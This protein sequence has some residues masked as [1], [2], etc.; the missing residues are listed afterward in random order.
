MPETGTSP[1][2]LV[3]AERWARLRA[4]PDL[5]LLRQAAAALAATTE[6][7]VADRT[8][9]GDDTSHNWHLIRARHAQTRIVSL[10]VRYGLT[11][12]RRYRE[13]AL[14]YVRDMAA[15]EYWSWITWREGDPDLNA[16]FDL[17]YGENAATLALT[18]D[19]L[20][21][22]LSAE[23]RALIV[24]TART[25]A[26]IPYLARN[27]TPGQEMW[28]FRKPDCNWNTVCNGGAGLL[29]L[30]LGDLAPESARVLEL[31]EEGVRH[32]FEF[33][34]EDGAW[35]EGLGYWG[36]GHRYGYL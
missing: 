25:R 30:A 20:A 26:L 24:D 8:I 29:A 1:R 27:G 28:Y 6:P 21:G 11:G 23:E 31:V 36:Y 9:P 2:L 3:S 13:A 35:P 15:W 32:Y 4:L 34:Q 12:D 16:I 17:S 33:L 7:W 19:W 14:E 18:Y 22:E 10:L 5:P